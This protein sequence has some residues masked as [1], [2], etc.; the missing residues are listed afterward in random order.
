MHG[1]IVTARWM[2]LIGC[3]DSSTPR[4][5]APNCGAEEKT[6]SLRSE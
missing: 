3:D 4:P 1:E 5:G 2:R 6:G